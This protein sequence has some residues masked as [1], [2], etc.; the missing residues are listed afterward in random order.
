MRK[1]VQIRF[2]EVCESRTEVVQVETTQLLNVCKCTFRAIFGAASEL[3][4][5]CFSLMID[6]LLAGRARPPQFPE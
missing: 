3:S 2:T 4:P 6:G 5:F 1:T